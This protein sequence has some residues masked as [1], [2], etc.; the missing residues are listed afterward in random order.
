ME[1]QLPPTKEYRWEDNPEEKR[2]YDFYSDRLS[3]TS[4]SHI[5]YGCSDRMGN[6]PNQLIDEHDRRVFMNALQWL[7]SPVGQSFMKEL[8]QEKL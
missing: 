3:D 6:P 4:M 8:M 1:K 7:G 5:I 2:I